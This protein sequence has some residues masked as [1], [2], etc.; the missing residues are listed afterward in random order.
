MASH[1]V[2]LY[3]LGGGG[4]FHFSDFGPSSGLAAFLGDEVLPVASSSDATRN[5]FGAQLGAG[6]DFGVGPASLY[7]RVARSSTS[8]A[9]V[10]TTPNFANVFGGG[11]G[12]DV[13]WVPI[14]L[15]VTFR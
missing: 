15:G 2:N 6:I 11:F 7:R 10:T 9:G 1:T 13:R 8:S 14:M 3:G 12:K 5:E 4:I